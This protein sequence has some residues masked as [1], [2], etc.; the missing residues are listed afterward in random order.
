[1]K[2]Y[3]VHTCSNCPFFYDSYNKE[4]QTNDSMWPYTCTRS[5]RKQICDDPKR[6]IPDWCSLEDAPEGMNRYN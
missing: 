4:W 3:K 5:R 1:M 2:I 6:G